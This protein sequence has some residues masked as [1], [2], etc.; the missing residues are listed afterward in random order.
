MNQQHRMDDATLVFFDKELEKVKKQTYDVKYNDILARTLFPVDPDAAGPGATSISYRQFDQVG[1]AK[2]IS[3]YADDLPRVD[4]AGKQFFSPVH[5]LGASYGWNI[6]ELRAAMMAKLNLN[7][8]RAIAAREAILRK[9]HKLALFGDTLTGLPGFLSNPNISVVTAADNGS[10]A[11]EWS[12]KTPDQILADMNNA[13]GAIMT[14]TN[15]VEKPNTLLLPVDEYVR[16]STTRMT[17]GATETVL[18]FFL[19]T[20]AALGAIDKVYALP[21]LTEPTAGWASL[22]VSFDE[23]KLMVVYN[24]DPMKLSMQ[25]ASDFETLPVEERGLDNIVNCME[26]FGGVLIYYPLSVMVVEGI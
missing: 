24:R 22:G 2:I 14:L 13:V 6:K 19:K 18:S 26:S 17:D 3:D 15:G 7:A 10:G 4:V 5:E 12:A 25:V 21:E 11:T 8:R 9:E 20:Q 16:V 23:P 1:I